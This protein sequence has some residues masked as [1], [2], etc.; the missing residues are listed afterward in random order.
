[1]DEVG[2]AQKIP[3]QKVY[4]SVPDFSESVRDNGFGTPATL[5]ILPEGY[6]DDETVSLLFDN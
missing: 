1:M 4:L 2:G 6:S 3:Q 5:L